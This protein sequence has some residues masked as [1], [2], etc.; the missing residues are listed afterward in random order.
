M[1]TSRQAIDRLVLR[2][3]ETLRSRAYDYGTER[4]RTF[5]V[6]VAAGLPE[7]EADEAAD[8]VMDMVS[9]DPP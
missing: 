9:S 2:R 6:F 7:D 4:A 8:R 1:A 3:V 5:A